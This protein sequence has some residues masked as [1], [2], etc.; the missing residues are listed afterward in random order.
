L[1]SE[2]PLSSHS[3]KQALAREDESRGHRHEAPSVSCMFSSP[4]ESENF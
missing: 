2:T 4:K 3:T 1:E